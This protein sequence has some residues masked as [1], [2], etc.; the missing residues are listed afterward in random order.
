MF[1][2]A[3]V[4]LMA[5]A[6]GLQGV[7]TRS[8]GRAGVAAMAVGVLAAGIGS[9]TGGS[10]SPSTSGP[11]PRRSEAMPR[12]DAIPL[13]FEA[14]AGQTDPSVRLAARGEGYGL[15]L[16]P[17]ETVL[18][19]QP[20]QPGAGPWVLRMA[21]RGAASQ[22]EVVGEQLLPG[23]VNYL[24][25]SDAANWQRGVDTYATARYRS[26]YPG[27]DL[28][29]YGRD[30][31]LE[32]DFVLAP[33]ADPSVIAMG[34]SGADRLS[35]SPE[36]DL[37][38]DG[39][40][41]QLRHAAPTLYQGEG[42]DRRTVEGRFVQRGPTEVGFEVGPYDPARPLVIDPI[43]DY[44]TYL[45]GGGTDYGRDI[46]VSGDNAYVTGSTDSL[47]FPL[48]DEA[49]ID[50]PGTDAFV[51]K[52]SAD[53][54]RLVYSTYLGG[55]AEDQGLGIAVGD[56]NAYVTGSTESTDFPVKSGRYQADQP[57]LDAFVVKLSP[58]GSDLDYSTYL[59]GGGADRAMGI[60]VA[61]GT[62]FVTGSTDSI[63]FPLVAA[64]QAD[65]PGPDAF[66]AKLRKDGSGLVFSTYL[67]GG[68]ADDG[69]S[70]AVDDGDA[71]VTG[72]TESTDFPLADPYQV[73]QPGTDGFVVKLS[74]SGDIEYGTYL[75]GAGAD[76]G[77]GIAA[78]DGN[79]YVTGSTASADFPIE[80]RLQTDQ[81]GTDAFVVK[82][83]RTGD[84]V[85]YSTYLG[86]ALEDR[87]LG[88]A[89]SDGSAY[90]TGGTASADFPTR[91]RYQADQPGLDAFVVKLR[92]DGT[93]LVY[94]SHLGGGG[95]DEGYAV[96]VAGGHA[97]L[98]GAT[99]S[100]NF[101]TKNR[102]QANQ[103]GI[104]SFVTKLG[105]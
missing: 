44:S 9:V 29:L 36:G 52:F 7:R 105:A 92:Q 101:P 45:G 93:Q 60:A 64:M 17:E 40:G 24:R 56:G 86:G 55:G 3:E 47:N 80:N 87:G 22:P 76:R 35:L 99:D 8:W 48:R 42:A 1:L 51:S 23:K 49:Q 79:A 85:V 16:T 14:N 39:P 6:R 103:V 78:D 71:Y 37:L 57:G 53:G 58:D 75:G 74:G 81:P 59:G 98:V 61:D 104:D 77:L 100:L 94:G 72:S 96:A 25:G 54:T 82:L 5:S 65:Q 28:V 102:I 12:F 33:G 10:S 31:R 46:A 20:A 95:S 97:Y 67:G 88:I 26:V 73:D 50:K 4:E 38:I 68:A 84:D 18:R 43:L 90:V 2:G 11:T 63:D 27:T 66:V 13:T 89:V 41:A 91:N 34:F 15:F 19:L 30:G 21:L 62:A 32:Y 70:I 83:T 69:L